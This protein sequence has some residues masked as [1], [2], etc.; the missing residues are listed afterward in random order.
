VHSF[1]HFQELREILANPKGNTLPLTENATNTAVPCC[2]EAAEEIDRIL[3][4]LTTSLLIMDDL[5]EFR[6]TGLLGPQGVVQDQTP[7]R[8]R[9]F[10]MI[11]YPE[12]V[13]DKALLLVREVRSK[14][15]EIQLAGLY[16]IPGRLIE[17]ET[18]D[19]L[20]WY[21]DE[22]WVDERAARIKQV[23]DWVRSPG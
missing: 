3:P 15:R 2:I 12:P 14:A 9:R 16:R 17:G 20:S 18:A 7:K 22:L 13:G 4:D 1:C 10:Q 8:P 11:L 6:W 19:V 21:S 23:V 5:R